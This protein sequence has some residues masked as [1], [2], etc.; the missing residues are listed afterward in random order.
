MELAWKHMGTARFDDETK[1]LLVKQ[2]GASYGAS[3]FYAL[4]E[5]RDE[6]EV[7]V[8]GGLARVR[9]AS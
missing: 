9:S 5:V 8:I 2:L 3:S 4:S 6:K 7:A 1:T